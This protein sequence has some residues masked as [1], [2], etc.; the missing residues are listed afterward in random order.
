MLDAFFIKIIFHLSV[1]ELGSIV[2][3]YLLEFSI[4]LILSSL[5][6]FLERILCF[7]LIMQTKYSHEMRIII[8][9]DNT[10]FVTANTNVG[11]RTE[12]VHMKHLQGSYCCHNVFNMVR[13][14]NLLV[15]LTCSTR[16]N[17]SNTTFVSPKMLPSFWSLL[18][19]LIPIWASFRCHNQPI[20]IFVIKQV[21]SYTFSRIKS[22][23]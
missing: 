23:R 3:P 11:D 14:S 15:G 12:Q 8:N 1:L 6:K 16:P 4:E 7:T 18:R 19:F 10:I 2:T 9:N 20:F 13:C 5:Q 21:S 17:F 22:I